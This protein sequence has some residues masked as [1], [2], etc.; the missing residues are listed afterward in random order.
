M[1]GFG[2][3]AVEAMAHLQKLIV[4]DIPA[5]REIC[6]DSGNYFDPN[7]TDDLEKKLAQ[8]VDDPDN[9]MYLK[10]IKAGAARLEQFSWEKMAK[11]TLRVYENVL[12]TEKSQ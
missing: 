6:A 3:P 2:L 12:S 7:D 4:S 9:P 11:E 10:K 1:E 8:V 5:F